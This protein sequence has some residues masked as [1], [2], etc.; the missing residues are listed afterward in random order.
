MIVLNINKQR[1]TRVDNEIIV[2]DTINYLEVSCQFSN[3]WDGLA[4]I[5]HFSKN[6]VIY[7]FLLD[8]Y[9]NINESAGLSLDSGMWEIYIHG[10]TD[11]R[12]AV[13]SKIQIYVTESGIL[14]GEPIPEIDVSVAEQILNAANEALLAASNTI[15]K[16]NTLEYIPTGSY[17]PATKNYV[18][19]TKLKSSSPNGIEYIITVTDEGLL[20]ATPV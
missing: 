20:V 1:L 16:D 12:R 19:S 2:S 9:N 13:S 4:K 18:D 5:V 7:D 10:S 15:S 11:T 8:Q 14:N 6:G 3:D 17:N